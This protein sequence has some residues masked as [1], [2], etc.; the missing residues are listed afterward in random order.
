MLDNG[1][2]GGSMKLVFVRLIR[3]LCAIVLILFQFSCS[4]PNVAAIKPEQR[5]IMNDQI[6]LPSAGGSAGNFNARIIFMADQLERNLD[7]KGLSNSFIV[8]SFAN[9]NRLSETTPFGR[10]VSENMIH[11]LQVRKWQVF[12]VRLT[13]DIIINETGEFSLSRDIKKL[14]EQYKIGGIV[15]GTYSVTGSN[16]IVNARVIDINT[17]IVL[18]SA[19]AIMPANLFAENLLLSDDK[20][21]EKREESIKVMKIVGDTAYSCRDIPTC[22]ASDNSQFFKKIQGG[23]N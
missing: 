4:S 20:R 13:K 18:S 22:S 12:E 1:L 10:L 19:Q 7:R 17:G 14:K 9:L 3:L 23:S 5:H 2:I 6:A 21:E 8:T 11:E 16:I 15:T